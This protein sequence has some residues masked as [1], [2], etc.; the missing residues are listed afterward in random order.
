MITWQEKPTT[1]CAWCGA[2]EVDDG[3]VQ[4]LGR[5]PGDVWLSRGICPDC[6]AA[7]L[8]ADHVGTDAP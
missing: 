5:P 6:A 4:P 8:E 1:V 2:T 7:Q 3:W